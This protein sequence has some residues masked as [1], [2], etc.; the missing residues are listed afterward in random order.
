M[1]P[2]E[3][4]ALQGVE[5]PR[6]AELEKSQSIQVAGIDE[7]VPTGLVPARLAERR[8]S[9]G[10][11]TAAKPHKSDIFGTRSPLPDGRLRKRTRAAARDVALAEPVPTSPASPHLAKGRR[12]YGRKTENLDFRWPPEARRVRTVEISLHQSCATR[13]GLPDGTGLGGQRHS[14]AKRRP[15]Y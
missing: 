7:R 8:R 10:H 5:C 9:Y 6:T 4:R 1:R 15:I 14:A 2:K 13:R 12:S 11:S 3:G